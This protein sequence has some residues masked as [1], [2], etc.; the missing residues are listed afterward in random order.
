MNSFKNDP[1]VGISISIIRLRDK[2]FW[3]VK[4][5]KIWAIIW[6]FLFFHL[7][8]EWIWKKERKESRMTFWFGTLAV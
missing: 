8:T 2:E 7:I 3:E 1:S 5:G 6:K 4:L